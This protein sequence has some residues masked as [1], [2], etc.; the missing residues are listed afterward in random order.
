[1]ADSNER[2]DELAERAKQASER[3]HA[4]ASTTKEKLDSEVSAARASAEETNRQL[5]HKAAGAR[6]EASNH[7][8]AVRQNWNTHIAEMRRKADEQKATL[9]LARAKNR[10]DDRED[11]AVMAVDFALQAVEE[12][13]YEVL[14]AILARTEANEMA[15]AS[16]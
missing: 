13:E 15:G 7:W 2:M 9:D 3:V 8:S 1:M 6:D 12:A 10:A 5:E 4:S 16:A 11:D 14:D